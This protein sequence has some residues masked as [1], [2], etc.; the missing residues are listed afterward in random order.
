[1][2]VSLESA[3]DDSGEAEVSEPEFDEEGGSEDSEQGEDGS[4]SED[5]EGEDQSD[6]LKI[7]YAY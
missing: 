5:V 4:E 7:E 6:S 1:M 2:N 3:G